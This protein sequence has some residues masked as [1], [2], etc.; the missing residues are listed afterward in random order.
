MI[1]AGTAHAAKHHVY[2]ETNSEAGNAIIAFNREANGL[3]SH[4][5]IFSTGGRG[6]AGNPQFPL[7][8]ADS[9]GPIALTPDN[10][11]LFA[12]NIGSGT[13][14]SF[15]VLGDR[16]I[17]V[18]VV[19]AGGPFPSAIDARRG[20][21]FVTHADP[22]T[23]NGYRYDSRGHL[24]PIAGATINLQENSLPAAVRIDPAGRYLA[25]AERVGN[26]V[27]QYPLSSS[28][29][30]GAPINHPA[31]GLAPFG[32]AVSRSG[33][34]VSGES[35]DPMGMGDSRVTTYSSATGGGLTALDSYA[36]NLTATCWVVL[37]KDERYG[38]ASSA[39]GG[40]SRF[41]LSSAGKMALLGTTRV[42]DQGATD[43]EKSRD[44]RYLYVLSLNVDPTVPL[45][46]STRVEVFRIGAGGTLTKV[47]QT[48]SFMPGTTSGLVAS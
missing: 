11:L 24:T 27:A 47:G 36:D 22:A 2:V 39:D 19:G 40:I 46:K 25:V 12:S 4:A 5:R 44:G 13:I 37:T 33:L 35:G 7:A 3:L 6:G 21:L 16:L 43:E 17:R 9:Q 42:F 28:G 30:P 20:M 31:V 10:K 23:M 45:L 38:F 34:I 41:S 29:I 26:Q 8:L 32:L 15:R 1:P 14:T 18:A 48:P